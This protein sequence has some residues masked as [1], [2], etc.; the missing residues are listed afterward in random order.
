MTPQCIENIIQLFRS[1]F[2]F[3]HEIDKHTHVDISINCDILFFRGFEKIFLKHDEQFIYMNKI[4]L[5]L[6][7]LLICFVGHKRKRV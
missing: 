3:P 5:R 6:V 1:V 7:I 2:L 4:K